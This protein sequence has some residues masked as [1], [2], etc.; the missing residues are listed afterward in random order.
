MVE[1]RKWITA[2]KTIYHFLR[3]AIVHFRALNCILSFINEVCFKL[4]EREYFQNVV[5]IIENLYIIV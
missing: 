5:A 1:L 2:Q 4:Y 3:H